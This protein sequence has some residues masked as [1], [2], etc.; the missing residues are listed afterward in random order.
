MSSIRPAC[1]AELAAQG[2][3]AAA[4]GD[5]LPKLSPHDLR[6]LF[7]SRLLQAGERPEVVRALMGHRSQKM[8]DYYSHVELEPKI[9]AV[10]RLEQAAMR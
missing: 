8:T 7:C 9:E 1:D 3:G 2:L 5:G 10:H 4:S 6:H